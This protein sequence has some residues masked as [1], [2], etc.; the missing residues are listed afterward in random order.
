MDDVSIKDP[1]CWVCGGGTPFASKPVPEAV[2]F[3]QM[4]ESDPFK[5]VIVRVIELFAQR[6]E[7]NSDTYAE[8]VE[9]LRGLYTTL[10]GDAKCSQT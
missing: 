6:K 9:L 10:Q 8:H 3:S 1:R 5:P 7:V 2:A 4:N